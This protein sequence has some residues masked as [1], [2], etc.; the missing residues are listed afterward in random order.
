MKQTEQKD[1]LEHLWQQQPTRNIDPEVLKRRVVKMRLKQALYALIDFLGIAV[2]AAMILN[3]RDDMS[4]FFFNLVLVVI[5]LN[6]IYVSYV[7]YLRRFV[8]FNQSQSTREYMTTLNK[9]IRSNVRIAEYTKHSCWISFILVVVLF[10]VI[11]VTEDI[12]LDEW[13]RKLA[14]G[15]GVAALFCIPLWFWSRGREAKFRRELEM[16]EKYE[17]L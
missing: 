15:I 1:P 7:F 5:L 3:Y 13:R 8:L 11:G 2:C 9:Q 17:L 16:I 10:L 4:A 14:M 6:L 12:S